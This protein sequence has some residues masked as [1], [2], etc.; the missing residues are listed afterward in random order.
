MLDLL[1][2][3]TDVLHPHHVKVGPDIHGGPYDLETYAREWTRISQAFG[4]AGTVIA[5]EFMAFSNIPTVAR[6]VELVRASGHPAGG[7][8]MDMWHIWRGGAEQVEQIADVPLE[9]DH[10]RRGSTTAPPSPRWTAPTRRRCSGATS[11]GRARCR[12]RG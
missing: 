12:S 1:L 11:P 8:M 9:P 5:L 7:L 3:A 4:D 2:R 6:A 10:R